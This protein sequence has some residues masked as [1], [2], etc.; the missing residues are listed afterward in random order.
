[1]LITQGPYLVSRLGGSCSQPGAWGGPDQDECCDF[2][3]AGVPRGTAGLGI[4]GH[5]AALNLATLLIP[6]RAGAQLGTFS[7]QKAARRWRFR[8]KVLAQ[9]LAWDEEAHGRREPG[10]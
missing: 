5:L 8:R 7:G 9:R 6:T 10:S 3:P 2:G 4:T 1:M